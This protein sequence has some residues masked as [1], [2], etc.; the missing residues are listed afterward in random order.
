MQFLLH[1]LRRI[2]FDAIVFQSSGLNP[3]RHDQS[4]L[5]NPFLA[6]CEMESA[7]QAMYGGEHAK[8]CICLKILD[9]I[10]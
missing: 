3:E 2:Q 9:P 4:T 5:T 10:R 6:I 8:S 7:L 1:L